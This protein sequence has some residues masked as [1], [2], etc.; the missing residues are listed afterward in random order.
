M[1]LSKKLSIR[2]EVLSFRE[3]LQTVVNLLTSQKIRVVD[4]GNSAYCAYDKKTNELNYINIPSIPDNASDKLLF[5][6][7]GFIDHEVAHVLFTNAE[8]N[9]LLGDTKSHRLWNVIEDTFIERKMSA[10]FQG[11]R[12]NLIKVQR[13]IVE[14]VF[15]PKI[16]NYIREYGKNTRA[17]FLD[18]FLMP[19][20]RAFCGHTTFVDFMEP[21][22]DM[23]ENELSVL[24]SINYKIRINR[25]T[26]SEGAAKL[27][28]DLLRAF[29][30]HD[31]N[32]KD[33]IPD[34]SKTEEEK[35]LGDSDKSADKPEPSEEK[36]EVSKDDEKAFD[37]YSDKKNNTYSHTEKKEKN[38]VKDKPEEEKK[39]E[40]SPE[41]STPDEPKI[42]DTSNGLNSASC[43]NDS[44]SHDDRESYGTKEIEA[45][46]KEFGGRTGD[47]IYDHQDTF[48]DDDISEEDAYDS[49]SRDSDKSKEPK[50][51]V[52][53]SEELS[54]DDLDEL[55][56]EDAP[57]S[58]S[59]EDA[60]N[61][62]ISDE[63]KT[64]AT[65]AY[66]PFSRAN[67]FMG[68]LENTHAFLKSETKI[69]DVVWID[70]Y[71]E[72][73]RFDEKVGLNAFRRCIEPQLTNKSHT[74]SKDLE[75]AIASRNRV[76][77]IGGLRR[78]KINPPS[79][80]KIALPN[81]NDDRVFARKE[82]NRAVN[83]AVQIV[84]DLSG[85]MGGKRI[86]LATAAA[87]ALSDALDKIKVPNIITGFTT[88]GRLKGLMRANRHEP[89]FL[90]TLK[91]WNE[92]ANS[93]VTRARLGMCIDDI[94]LRNN[95]D[96]ESILALS[97]HHAGRTEDKQIML[98]LSDGA[99]AA[100]GAGF[101]SHLVEVADFILNKAKIDI[102]AV[103][104]Q[105]SAPSSYYKYHTKVDSVDDLPKTVITAIR[106][107]LLGNGI[108][109]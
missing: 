68:L 53:D 62:M 14:S 97:R 52:P 15:E 75:R 88:I 91:N 86:M 105:T 33:R 101:E 4:F 70:K 69:P 109:F 76:Q 9:K 5:A 71:T 11:S 50:P 83:A 46:P 40:K 79:L 16:K 2:P 30:L 74:L 3:S 65:D 17:L 19:V 41:F 61:E 99:P 98:V 87:Y 96:G 58:K 94:P 90:P 39:S 100:E 20:S 32:K 80:W 102:L 38:K 56:S 54:K 10:M 6:I 24:D 49:D 29:R 106:N 93:S 107:V 21:Y 84:I 48:K 51:E 18:I 95:V 36:V 55:N 34:P 73:Y 45:P 67:D 1:S 85:S 64:I 92:K 44:L 23:F 78:G 82:E 35:S 104:I 42:G 63:M 37:Q 81:I 57:E 25:I 72:H 27:A 103:G 28:A 47:S 108:A 59:I 77:K 43:D 26:K 60:A 12:Q 13:H 22:W 66:T 8:I 7:R 31:E 89:L